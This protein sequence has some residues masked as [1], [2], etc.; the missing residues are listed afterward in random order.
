M[1][2]LDRLL[3]PASV[4]VIGGG[5]AANVVEQLRRIGYEG[6]IWPIHPSR[7]EIDGIVCFNSLN[8]LPNAPD[9]AFVGVNRERTVE[10]VEALRAMGAG[11]AVC[12]ASGF[13]E[14][15]GEATGGRDLQTRLVAAAG[16]MP[17]L[18]PN[19]YGFINYLDGVALWPD[20][21][22]G[23]RCDQGVAILTQSS[24]IAINMTM[25]RRGL[26]IAY[27]VTVGNQAQTSLATIGM[28]LLEDERVTA[29]GLHIEGIGDIAAFDAMAR[30]ASAL[31]KPIVALK[32]GHSE[33]ARAQTLTHTASLAGSR[34]G[35][36]AFLDRAGVAVVHTISVFLETLKLLHVHGPLAGGRLA[37]ISCSGGEASLMAD[38]AI[39]RDLVFPPLAA[40]QSRR[41]RAALG[42][43]VSLA[44]PL[45]Y[46]TYI[47]GKQDA[48]A[49]AFTAM[50]D[51]PLDLAMFVLDLPRPD[52]CSAQG[53]HVAL[54]AIRQAAAATGTKT[55]I[56]AS[57]PEN[58]PEAL[59]EQLVGGGIAPL[60][61]MEEALLAAE[62]AARVGAGL[63][64]PLPPPPIAISP[65]PPDALTLDEAQAKAALAAHGLTVPRGLVCAG[66]R[67][68]VEAGRVIGYPVALKGLGIP[69]K[70]EAGAVAVGIAGKDEL[71]GAAGRMAGLTH[72]FLV[73]E[74]VA[75]AVCELIV[76]VVRDPAHGL[77]LTIG[78]GG[79]LAELLADT[80][81]LVLPAT[82]AAIREKL[83]T[84]KV[85]RL[86][87]GHRGRPA[88]DLDAAV[89]AIAAV[90]AY[91]AGE[92]GRLVELDVNPLIVTPTGAVAADAL[93]RLAAAEPAA[94]GEAAQ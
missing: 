85:A 48:M 54:A 40:T 19:C 10:V 37:S 31:A 43:M 18:G 23:R 50:L 38:L 28:E 55:A 64:R 11:G 70:S 73:E 52:R 75:D 93:I 36:L 6:A 76:G 24:N 72:G 41:L 2:R 32:T 51:A 17:I 89:A 71:I 53:W 42:P 46:H 80:A 67:D 92:A 7:D 87:A 35:A 59:A 68:L 82:E 78:A 49:R 22:G 84:L 83:A 25:Q 88:G 90:A 62:A 9:A 39:G 63:A 12:F 21:H 77:V 91:A 44:N 29:L 60:C 74:M 16:S 45:D 4:A 5:W 15:E 8:E 26:P 94:R 34:S 86:I 27:C 33:Q 56:V 81:S 65:L 79:V 61:G 30:R 66:V 58:M 57:L 47:W 20:Q 69:H 14:S 13:L 3:R 1:G